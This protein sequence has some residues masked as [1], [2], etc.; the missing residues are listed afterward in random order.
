MN[1]NPSVTTCVYFSM[2]SL[3]NPLVCSSPE[4][5]TFATPSLTLWS[6]FLLDLGNM[7]IYAVYFYHL[8]GLNSLYY[9]TGIFKCK[10]DVA[11]TKRSQFHFISTGFEI[12]IWR[13]I[14]WT[15]VNCTVDLSFIIKK[16]AAFFQGSLP[17][18]PSAVWWVLSLRNHTSKS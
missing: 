2:L 8:F 12:Y 6:T 16:L 13:K 15:V 11:A 5:T 9:N 14:A 4:R 7:K 17:C 3:D 10:R 1:T 18:P